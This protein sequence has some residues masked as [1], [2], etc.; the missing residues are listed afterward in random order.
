M[1]AQPRVLPV[2]QSEEATDG[3]DARQD[4]CILQLG[5]TRFQ[6]TAILHHINRPPEHDP[7]CITWIFSVLTLDLFRRIALSSPL[8]AGYF[9]AT[10]S[11]L[12]PM[13]ENSCRCSLRLKATSWA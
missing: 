11:S 12:S 4:E 1:Y 6:R 13:L 2:Q 7:I 3:Y 10:L 9:A 8:T 5:H